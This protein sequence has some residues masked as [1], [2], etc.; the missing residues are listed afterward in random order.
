MRQKENGSGAG[1]WFME[2]IEQSAGKRVDIGFRCVI[3]IEEQ[4]YLEK[5]QG[6]DVKM[7]QKRQK[8]IKTSEL[9]DQDAIIFS[10]ALWPEEPREIVFFEK[11]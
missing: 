3:P 10:L 4:N 2:L 11:S 5:M 7:N 9:E 8:T 6:I 1:T